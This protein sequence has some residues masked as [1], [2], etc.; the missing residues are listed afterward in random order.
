MVHRPPTPPPPPLV[1]YHV[2]EDRA[3]ARTRHAKHVDTMQIDHSRR[4]RGRKS[5]VFAAS[6]RK[7]KRD[8]RAFARGRRRAAPRRGTPA[9]PCSASCGADDA[10]SLRAGVVGGSRPRMSARSDARSALVAAR[11]RARAAG[12]AGPMFGGGDAESE[13]S[14][15]ERAADAE[16]APA[17]RRARERRAARARDARSVGV[18]RAPSFF[19]PGRKATY[20]R[21]PPPKTFPRA[22]STSSFICIGAHLVHLVEPPSAPNRTPSFGD[23]A[24]AARRGGAPR[25]WTP[26]DRRLVLLERRR[27]SRRERASRWRPG[28]PAGTPRRREN[29]LGALARASATEQTAALLRGFRMRLQNRSSTCRRVRGWRRARCPAE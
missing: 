15:E 13:K 10:A 9:A 17:L 4:G 8:V 19:L 14:G 24:R 29:R 11:G 18:S 3:H 21:S 22:A 27:T 26:P 2:R 6:S 5:P 20:T 16:C 25:T 7:Y 12:H 1:M 28:G 23:E